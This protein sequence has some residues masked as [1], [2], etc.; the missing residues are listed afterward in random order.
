MLLVYLI[1]ILFRNDICDLT[2]MWPVLSKLFFSRGLIKT[3]TTPH[4]T[5][6]F[7]ISISASVFTM[8]FIPFDS[9]YAIFYPLRKENLPKTEISVGNYMDLIKRL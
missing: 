3:N 8:T 5:Q 2:N 6:A 9:M 1:V 4:I 7:P